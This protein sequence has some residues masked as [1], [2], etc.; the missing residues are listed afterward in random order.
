MALSSKKLQQKRQ[1]KKA[2][3]QIKIKERTSSTLD[4][5]TW[6]IHECWVSAGL[7]ETGMGQAVLAR[8]SIFGD[9]AVGVYLIDSFCLGIKNCFVRVL[10]SQDFH[11]M[12][13]TVEASCGEMK[14]VEPTYINTLIHR[15]IDYAK[16]FNF[17]PHKDFNKAKQLL[18]NILIDET[19]EF[20]FGNDGK[21][22]YV[23]GPNDSSSDTKRILNTLK[24]T[25]G[26]GHYNYIVEV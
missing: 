3:R 2:K 5:S 12:L 8:K 21:P 13:N 1:K 14:R 16:Q 18:R 9:I 6:S 25:V 10:D 17:H 22:C 11:D 7:W 4:Y 20:Q 24:S 19:L 26:E 23:Q 15:A